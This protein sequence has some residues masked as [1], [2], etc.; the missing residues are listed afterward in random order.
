MI[1]SKVVLAKRLS[2]CLNPSL[3]SGVHQK[4]LEVYEYVFS[5]IGKAGLSR[6]LPLYFPGLSPT[7]SFAAL[8]VRSPFLDILQEHFTTLDPRSLR[9]AMKSIILALLPG[10]EDETAE[11]FD[12]TLKLLARFKEVIRQPDSELLTDVHSLADD[13]FWQCFFLASITSPSRRAGAL[14]YLSRFLPSLGHGTTPSDSQGSS[15]NNGTSDR[16]AQ[17]LAAVVT[18]PEPGLLIRCIA[19]GLTD[20]Q[21]LIQR[22]FLDLLVTHL[23]LD[24]QVLQEKVKSADLEL[25]MKA[26]TGVV[27]RREMSLN[28]RLWSWLLGPDPTAHEVDQVNESSGAHDQHSTSA[29]KTNYFEDYGLQSLTKA[30]LDMV[31]DPNPRNVAERA[32]PYRV[33]LSLMDRW[34]IGGMIVPEVF[35]PIIQSVQQFQQRTSA[36]DDFQEVLRSASVFFDGIESGLIFGELLSL[37]AQAI[38][39]GGA[40][41]DDRDDKLALVDFVLKNFNVREEEMVTIH[42][43]LCCI[44]V[45]AMLDDA[46]QRREAS[47]TTD[48][49]SASLTE[50]VLGLAISLLELIPERAFVRKSTKS[51]IAKPEESA[52]AAAPISNSDILQKIRRFYIN[53]QGNLDSGPL[54]LAVSSCSELILQKAVHFVSQDDTL[55]AGRN[56][57]L[58]ARVRIL[59]LSLVKVPT[60]CS[61]DVR[62]LVSH[63]QERLDSSSR[64]PFPDFASVVQLTVQLCTFDRMAVADLEDMIP[65]LTRHAWSYLVATD[66][67]YHVETVRCLWQLQTTLTVRSRNIEAALATIVANLTSEGSGK[68]LCRAE[69]CRTFGILWLHTLQ[70]NPSDRRALKTPMA[71]YRAFPRLAG[72]DNYEVMLAQPLFLLLD[73][74]LDERT[75]L[76]LSVKSWLNSIIG[77]DR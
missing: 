43:P 7:L 22:G 34:E 66:P 62:K 1:P 75:R 63:L 76:H 21:L 33:C 20:E 50:R 71:E 40:S 5:V 65:S 28:R 15:A 48:N 4:A 16:L 37:L 72:M 17:G 31:R 67:K 13:F 24:S 29:A 18:S 8:S 70:D 26:A 27:T 56:C 77:I 44:A 45:L 51:N 52:R 58:A 11:D 12:R 35:L 61:L 53:E 38:G 14:S 19:S 55:D 59:L 47:K 2:Q 69:V 36:K 23:P 25:L 3:P 74:L 39:P 73:A 46:N 64:L 6:D 30:I 10:L 41:V 60:S 54:P 49:W 32:R 42:V 68:E 9:P 57:S